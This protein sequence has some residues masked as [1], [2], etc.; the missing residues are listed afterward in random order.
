MQINTIV[1]REVEPREIDTRWY[2]I[3]YSKIFSIRSSFACCTQGNM[4]FLHGGYNTDKGI[5]SD[6][7]QT[8]MNDDSKERKWSRVQ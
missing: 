3:K 2:E 8:E 6:F 4:V 5:L 1:D 7:Y